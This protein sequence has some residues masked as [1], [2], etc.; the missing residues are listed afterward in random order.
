MIRT[1]RGKQAA[2][3][4]TFVLPVDEPDG[5]VS[6][7]GDFNGWQPGQHELRKRTN[8]T[9]STSVEVDPGTTLRFRYL[10]TGGVWFD[11][12]HAHRH[13]EHGSLFTVEV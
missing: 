3:K 6:V 1:T 12:P 5:R 8:G 13:D 4:V 11:D 2:V 7:V 9:R 10:G